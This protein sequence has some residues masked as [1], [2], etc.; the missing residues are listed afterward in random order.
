MV[1]GHHIA[2]GRNDDARTARTLLAIL[3]LAIAARTLLREPEKLQERVVAE[4]PAPGYLDLLNG[5]DIDHRLDR[6]LGGIGEVGILPRLVSGE[7]RPEGRGPL[8]LALDVLDLRT[9][10]GLGDGPG[11]HT[12]GNGSGRNN[13]QKQKC[14]FHNRMMV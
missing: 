7:M 9:A 6:V 2:V 5:L 11:R 1:V 12:A 3:G 14:L 8:D 10:S 4:L 13:S